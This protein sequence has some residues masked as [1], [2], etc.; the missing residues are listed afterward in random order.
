MSKK[1]NMTI[2]F[3][4]TQMDMFDFALQ[5]V[6]HNM[7]NRTSYLLS[8]IR[9]DIKDYLDLPDDISLPDEQL[10]KLASKR[11]EGNIKSI[12]GEENYEILL[13]EMKEREKGEDK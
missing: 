13:K 12:V 10:I 11:N 1:T 4:E 8:A 3:N 9:Q 2:T 7:L 5:I 6:N